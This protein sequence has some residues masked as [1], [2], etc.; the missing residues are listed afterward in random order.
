MVLGV[1]TRLVLAGAV[2]GASLLTLATADAQ[3]DPMTPGPTPGIPQTPPGA[4]PTFQPV[5]LEPLQDAGTGGSGSMMPPPAFPSPF[6]TDAGVGGAGGFTPPS[7]LG[8][9]DAGLF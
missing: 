6:D 8:G 9:P 4:S 7:S 3:M 1:K 2:L 5:P